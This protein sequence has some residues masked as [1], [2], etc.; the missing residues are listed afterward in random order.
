MSAEPQPRTGRETARL[1]TVVV[2]LAGRD[3]DDDALALAA[4]LAD[5]ERGEIVPFHADVHHLRRSSPADGLV[6]AASRH[7]ADVVVI[8]SG[9]RAPAGRA[10]ATR[11]AMRL[12]QRGRCPVAVAPRDLRGTEPV[13]HL[14]VAYDGSPEAE[15]ALSVAYALAV[16]HGAAVSLYWTLVDGRVAYAGVPEYGM[17]EQR[18]RIQAQ[19][20]LDAAADRAP[21]GVNPE[22]VL[23][24]G[25]PASDI[26]SAADGVLDL[27]VTATRGAG[28]L[29][30][31]AG[32]SVAEQLLI[33][34]TVPV[35]V[36]PPVTHR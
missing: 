10:A 14:G 31:M 1:A 15:A 8:G 20:A 33:A 19:E 23:L 16:A 28:S 36:V 3:D 17:A 12:L 30:W 29:R 13:R 35:L 5:P 26:A 7:H 34:S 11:T 6:E 9:R 22:T 21:A 18:I 25:D 24:R 27:L 4:R 2:G 32:F